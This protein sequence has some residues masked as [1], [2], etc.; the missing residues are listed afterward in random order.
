[1]TQLEH[2]FERSVPGRARQGE[3]MSPRLQQLLRL[4]GPSANNGRVLEALERTIAGHPVGYFSSPGFGSDAREG[5]ESAFS[6]VC[7][8]ESPVC[9]D[10]HVQ[11][12]QSQV[13][14]RATP[15]A[16]PSFIGHMTS[17]LPSYLLPLA[18]IMTALN[19]NP[20][21]LETSNAFTPLER[22][23]LGMLHRLIYG[24]D[25]D[26]YRQTLHSGEHALGAFCAG[27]T[28]ANITALWASRNNLLPAD[29]G[30]AGV[31]REGLAKGLKHYG[32][33]GL[34]LLVSERGHYSLKKAADLLGIGQDQLIAVPTDGA[35]RIRIDALQRCLERL[36]LDNIKPLALVG[37]AGT[38][39]TGAIDDLD[40][41]A[42]VA[43]QAGCHFHVDAAW[44]ARA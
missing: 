41:M 30:F 34:A 31:A 40:A 36:R 22:Q 38:T 3:P 19:Q 28:T 11:Y 32:Y 25:E 44:G 42:D 43:A 14:S 35:E 10:E 20:V 18:K 17:A 23:V 6:S 12:L 33:D 2:G 29:K 39:E 37:I 24:N 26:F 8:P 7:L 4:F 21:K 15:T 1:M 16:S 9:L 13:F 27:G 5:L